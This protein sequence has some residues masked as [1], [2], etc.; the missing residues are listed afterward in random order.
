MTV[1]RIVTA[2]VAL[3]ALTLVGCSDRG[4]TTVDTANRVG[5]SVTS[6]SGDH[7]ASLVEGPS[8]G[9]VGTAVVVV[10]DAQGDELFRTPEPYSTRHGVAIA[11]QLDDDV[12]WV[13]SSDVG[14]SRVEQGASA[15]EQV[16]LTPATRGDVP[17]EIDALR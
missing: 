7:L 9:G 6:P 17:P 3:M 12:L 1:P 8:D 14:T 15:W 13:L 4:G 10:A 16:W 5:Q 2:A 11:W